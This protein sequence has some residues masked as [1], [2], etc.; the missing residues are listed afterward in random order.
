MRLEPLGS[1]RRRQRAQ[2][3]GESML[4]ISK[5][6]GTRTDLDPQDHA[7]LC[8]RTS[9]LR[10]VRVAKPCGKGPVPVDL[11]TRRH[12]TEPYDPHASRAADVRHPKSGMSKHPTLGCAAVSSTT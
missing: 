8:N 3:G 5:G 10:R 11:G 7:R 2:P 9:L 6:S 12:A 4:G 1:L